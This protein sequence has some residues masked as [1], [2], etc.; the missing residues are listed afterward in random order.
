MDGRAV[1]ITGASAGVG[2]AVAREFA[3]QGA[4]IGLIARGVDGL[5]AAKKEIEEI[6][7][8][9]LLLP[10][11]VTDAGSVDRAAQQV[12]DTFGPIEIWVNNAMATVFAPIKDL[13]PDEIKRVTDVTYLGVV[14]GTMAALRRMLPRDYGTIVQ[15]GS[16]LAYRGIP[17]QAAYCGAKHAIQGFDDSLY[18]ELL[19][20]KSKVRLT[21]VNLPAINTPQ[22]DW[23]KS[24]MPRRAQP[25]PPIFQPEVAAR[26]I[27][28]AADHHRR[29]LN[30]AWP[31]T[32]AIVGNNFFPGFGD[33]YLAEHGYDRQMTDEAED[34]NRPNNLWEPVAG[35]HGAHGR[36][37]DR[38]RD[39]SVELELNLNRSKIAPFAALALNAVAAALRQR[40]DPKARREREKRAATLSEQLRKRSTADLRRRRGVVGLSLV[41]SASM[42]L[43]AL[44]QMGM[45]KHLPE[46]PLPML[47]ADKVDASAEAYEKF[48]MPD[49]V[50]GFGSYAATMELAAMAGPDRAKDAPW[51]PL[52]L[53]AKVAFDV[54]NAAKLSVDQWTNHR[55]FCFWCLIAA[56]ATFATAPLVIP[57]AVAAAR[58]VMGRRAR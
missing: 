25:V 53:A 22:F 6:G 52:A 33:S 46:P 27:V 36:F 7:G 39:R 18:S 43:I 16:A 28:W 24:K 11:D 41:A 35:D 48:N 51:I 13:T 5:N 56:T 37:D 26:A 38:S 30:V 3:K 44:Y 20:D 4:K 50:L 45:I 34:P 31:T 47:N 55:A 8:E 1:V 19:H 42:G 12:E 54:A 2:R 58:V 49:A 9:A 40:R 10:L 23:S 15:V 21:M 57:E 29:E 17:L 32:K 14:Y